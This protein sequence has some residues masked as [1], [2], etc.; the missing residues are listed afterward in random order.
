[1]LSVFKHLTTLNA[2]KRPTKAINKSLSL[3]HP[4]YFGLNRF[5][6]LIRSFRSLTNSSDLSDPSE[7][8]KLLRFFRSIIPS[9]LSDPNGNDFASKNGDHFRIKKKLWIQ[10]IKMKSISEWG[11]KF[12]NSWESTQEMKWRKP[13][14][15]V[16]YLSHFSIFFFL[17]LDRLIDLF[18]NFRFDWLENNKNTWKSDHRSWHSEEI[19]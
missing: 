12:D 17:F 5:F 18:S 19:I 6:K 3:R 13:N 1:M 11:E 9:D 8:L 10:L 15:P 14:E 16:N 4:Y 2:L 7:S